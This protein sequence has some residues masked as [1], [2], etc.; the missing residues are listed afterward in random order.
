MVVDP[1]TP[2]VEVISATLFRDP[3][4]RTDTNAIVERY[5]DR[6]FR[7]G[8]RMSILQD[9]VVTVRSI[10]SVT[11]RTEHGNDIVP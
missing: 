7:S 2:R 10:V 4:Q 11:E 5:G 9:G 8:L 3:L 6:S 1:L